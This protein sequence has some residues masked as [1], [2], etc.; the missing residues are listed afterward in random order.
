MSERDVPAGSDDAAVLRTRA[1][2]LARREEAPSPLAAIDL[3]QFR[4]GR[5]RYAVETRHVVQ[6]LP[7]GD[8]TPVPCT[9]AFIAGVVNVRGRVMA[10]IDIQKFFGLPTRGLT[11]LHHI[12]L[13]RGGE[14]Q[15]GLLADA[16]VGVRADA[17][18]ALQPSLPAP[19]GVP[20]ECVIGMTADR[21]L[22]LD[23]DRMLADPRMTVN[24]E[25]NP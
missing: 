6:V 3:L 14:I 4:L 10:V 8:L 23:L 5:D 13:V 1:L 18:E 20:A 19:P 7:L 11:D 16:I 12:I 9:P 21:L 25:V 17:R 15:L 2:A 22:V 24:E